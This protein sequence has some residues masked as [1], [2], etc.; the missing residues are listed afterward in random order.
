MP[1]LADGRIEVVVVLRAEAADAVTVVGAVELP[2]VVGVHGGAPLHGLHVAV[3]EEEIAR[4]AVGA[5]RV[6][7][8]LAGRAPLAEIGTGADALQDHELGSGLLD[9][10]LIGAA[11]AAAVAEAIRARIVAAG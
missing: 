6:R 3:R 11:G 8:R 7:A 2:H 10:R 9:L 5:L 4:A 1:R